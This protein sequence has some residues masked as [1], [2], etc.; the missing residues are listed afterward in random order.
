MEGQAHSCILTVWKQG[1]VSHYLVLSFIWNN[2]WVKCPW[3]VR[4]PA[5]GSRYRA[6]WSE[7][8]LSI[9]H[10]IQELHCSST[11]WEEE[12]QQHKFL[13]RTNP[14]ASREKSELCIHTNWSLE[15][16]HG[17]PH[18]SEIA[19]THDFSIALTQERNP[20]RWSASA[21]Q[22]LLLQ[23]PKCTRRQK[24]SPTSTL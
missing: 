2:I 23:L 9:T 8:S 10:G 24:S 18:P 22:L 15:C 16:I 5:V 13:I 4:I 20:E 12:Q 17:N 19:A 6:T 14:P 1:R 3:C 7:L 21:I 11:K